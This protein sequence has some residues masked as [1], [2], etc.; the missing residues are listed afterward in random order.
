MILRHRQ[1][2]NHQIDPFFNVFFI[3]TFQDFDS[4]FFQLRRPWRKRQ[5]R[6]LHLLSHLK[7]SWAIPLT[8]IPPTPTICTIFTSSSMSVLYYTHELC[9][10]RNEIWYDKNHPYY[11]VFVCGLHLRTRNSVVE[12]PDDSTSRS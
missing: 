8:P 2:I 6:A 4:K 9:N 10:S 11:R 3:M 5:L 7:K 1:R 12:L